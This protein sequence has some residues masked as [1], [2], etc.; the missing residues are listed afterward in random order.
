MPR[1]PGQG[2]AGARLGRSALGKWFWWLCCESDLPKRK[3]GC[4]PGPG[5]AAPSLSGRGLRGVR[6][7][8]PLLDGPSNVLLGEGERSEKAPKQEAS[9]RVIA[10]ARGPDLMAAEACVLKDAPFLPGILLCRATC[11]QVRYFSPGEV[12]SHSSFQFKAR[13]ALGIRA[14]G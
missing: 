2:Q 4:A 9:A 8:A 1:M 5:R 10:P 13:T 12:R 6:N 3:W 14:G 11:L 7:D